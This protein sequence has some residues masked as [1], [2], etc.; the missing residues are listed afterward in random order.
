VPEARRQLLRARAEAPDS[1]LAREAN[2]LLKRLEVVRAR[3]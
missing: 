3:S 2:D 1:A